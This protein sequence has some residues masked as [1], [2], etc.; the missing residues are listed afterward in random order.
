MGGTIASFVYGPPRPPLPVVPLSIPRDDERI[1]DLGSTL[2]HGAHVVIPGEWGF[3]LSVGPWV[4]TIQSNTIMR[5]AG[6]LLPTR[7]DHLKPLMKF[8][9][10]YNFALC[11]IS[12]SRGL[13]SSVHDG[14]L[15]PGDWPPVYVMGCALCMITNYTRNEADRILRVGVGTRTCKVQDSLIKVGI[16]WAPE[17]AAC[18]LPREALTAVK[19]L[20]IDGTEEMYLAVPTTDGG[21]TLLR[22]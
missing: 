14:C 9:N 10:D 11:L 5:I 12:D 18:E 4:E 16:E 15:P 17:L 2:T 1:I 6:V 3:S 20:T 7:F 19:V 8:C 13:L 22:R 21:K